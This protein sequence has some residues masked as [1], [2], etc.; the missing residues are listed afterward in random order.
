[1]KAVGIRELKAKLSQ[2]L[3]EVRRGEVILVTDRG[4]VVA[5][6]REP[7]DGSNG[8]DP[9]ER[10]LLPLV[11]KGRVRLGRAQDRDAIYRAT[12]IRVS[13]DAVLALLDEGRMEPPT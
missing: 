12:G 7:L 9:F 3:D 5:E 13:G 8:L 10:A 6:I 11:K 4:Q 1:M 2:V